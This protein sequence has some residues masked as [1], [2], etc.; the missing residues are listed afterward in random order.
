MDHD[1][2]KDAI[3]EAMEE[4][5]RKKEEQE[6]LR[7]GMWRLVEYILIILFGAGM[8]L[9]LLN[10]PIMESNNTNYSVIEMYEKMRSDESQA[11]E[12]GVDLQIEQK[13][14]HA[15]FYACQAGFMMVIGMIIG[16]T[17]MMLAEARYHTRKEI[18]DKL[19]V[20]LGFATLILTVITT[21]QGKSS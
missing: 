19:V 21:L 13:L 7:S 14:E 18:I 12:V 20:L 8:I 2:I 4:Y 3:V 1:E 5:D 9:L 10:L 6:L 15:R 17:V 16:L 11:N